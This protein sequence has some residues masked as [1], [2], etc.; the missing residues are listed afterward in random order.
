MLVQ[1]QPQYTQL[2]LTQHSHREWLAA[3]IRN[4][5]DTW[6]VQTFDESFRSHLGASVI[7]HECDAFL[8][9]SFRWMFRKVQPGRMYRL[10]NRGHREEQFITTYLRGIGL[11]CEVVG[12]DGEQRRI[13][14]VSGHFSGSCDGNAAMPP[15][16]YTP[17]RFLLEYKTNKTG[18]DFKRLRREGVQRVKP[19][20]YAQM[21]TY[22]KMFELQ[23][24]L[25]IC[26]NKDDDELHVEIVWLDWAY[27][28]RLIER[29]T[30][31][32]T[33]Q[34]RPRRISET[35]SHYVCTMCDASGV[36]HD[37][38]VPVKVNCR[39]CSF[40]VAAENKQWYCNGWQRM[41]PKEFIPKGCDKHTPLPR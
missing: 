1:I 3:Q 23:Y 2:D 21:C 18:S 27:A 39:S 37:V 20:H 4:D 38:K 31:I 6:S 11:T 35:P 41:L 32:I 10:F 14:A 34:T 12:E 28:D 33:A 13:Q 29:A 8:W 17:H 5:I 26:V 22:G 9:F 19:K 40:A 30:H 25:Y 16:Y 36:C 15:R 7:G 24:A